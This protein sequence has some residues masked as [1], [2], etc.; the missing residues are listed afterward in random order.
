[1]SNNSAETT[2]ISTTTTAIE[3]PNL[4]E[5]D[6]I[7]DNHELAILENA[8]IKEGQQQSSGVQASAIVNEEKHWPNGIV[9]YEYASHV[10]SDQ[11][12]KIDNTLKDL[13]TKLGHCIK[14]IK[15]K[16][17]SRLLVNTNG[18]HGCSSWIGFRNEE[19]QDISLSAYYGCISPGVIEHEFL[20]SIGIFH[21]QESF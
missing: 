3:E 10:K 1:M 8:V 4:F 19:K 20:H 6:I 17:A 14:F 15:S 16:S 12:Y 13:Q 18:H 5:G 2:E 21:H 11:K 9:Y 7:I